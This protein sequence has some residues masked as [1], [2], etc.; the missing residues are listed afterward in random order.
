MRVMGH[1][2]SGKQPLGRKWEFHFVLLQK[3]MFLTRSRKCLTM[4]ALDI[5]SDPAKNKNELLD[6]FR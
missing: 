6:A 1:R 2:R 5:K 4:V 3:K